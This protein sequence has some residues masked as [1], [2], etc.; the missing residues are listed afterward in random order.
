MFST[1]GTHIVCQTQPS[2]A[3][4][5]GLV[6]MAFDNAEIS[7]TEDTYQY[8]ED[9]EL[10]DVSRHK[11][12]ISGG[13]LVIVFGTNLDSVQY[14]KMYVNHQ[15][16]EFFGV[17]RKF[18]ETLI[19]IDKWCF[20]THGYPYLKCPIGE[21]GYDLIAVTRFQLLRSHVNKYNTI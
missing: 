10:V 5:E 11:S 12:I 21:S 15:D 4:L 2:A 6:Q 13:L 17:S 3:R 1:S 18:C 7:F 16:M 8:V 9:P 14:P 19:L 20:R